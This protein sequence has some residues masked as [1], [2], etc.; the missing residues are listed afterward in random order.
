MARI[1]VYGTTRFFYLQPS[2]NT[3]K[4]RNFVMLPIAQRGQPLPEVVKA[5]ALTVRDTDYDVQESVWT[6]GDGWQGGDTRVEQPIAGLE[7][8]MKALGYAMALIEPVDATDWTNTLTA[9][10]LS[11]I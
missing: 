3:F 6:L 5:L 8:E 10:D 7:T 1:V 11:E 4:S 9:L 2:L